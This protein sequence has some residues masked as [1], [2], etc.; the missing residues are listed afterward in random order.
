H[1]RL[2]TQRHP[3]APARLLAARRRFE[4]RLAAPGLA[5][6]VERFDRE[7]YNPNASVAENLLFGTPIGGTFEGDA[8]AQHFYVQ[9]VLE[10]DGLADDLLRIGHQ[11]ARMMVELFG[12]LGPEHRL[13]EEF[14]VIGA[15][16]LR[17]LERIVARAER[18]GIDVLP[19]RDSE[20]LIGLALRLVAAGD[21]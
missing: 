21:R 8:L 9:S 4:Q 15:E 20:R 10:Q 1:G 16:E 14:G 6:F 2:D 7:R 13:S 3:D 5:R 19:A 12:D 18:R 17:Q 11:L